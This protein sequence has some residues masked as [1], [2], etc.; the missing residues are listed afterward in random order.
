MLWEHHIVCKSLRWMTLFHNGWI[1]CASKRKSQINA[2]IWLIIHICLYMYMFVLWQSILLRI[3][4]RTLTRCFNYRSCDFHLERSWHR[5]EVA[6]WNP[7][8][9]SVG[10]CTYIVY[11]HFVIWLTCKVW[12]KSKS[13]WRGMLNDVSFFFLARPIDIAFYLLGFTLLSGI[14]ILKQ[15]Y[16]PNTPK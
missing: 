1:M 13:R 11:Y 10:I 8:I 14:D 4:N 6:E 3:Q 15:I 16:A 2:C 5:S 7:D 12:W 9:K